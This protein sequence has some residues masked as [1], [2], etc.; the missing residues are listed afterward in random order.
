MWPT[1]HR[2]TVRIVASWLC[3]QAKASPPLPHL[4]G[5]DEAFVEALKSGAPCLWLPPSGRQG[6]QEG[7]ERPFHRSEGLLICSQVQHSTLA[8]QHCRTNR[9]QVTHNALPVLP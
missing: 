7:V 9:L 4:C 6:T 8:R 1:L 3:A 5:H 2:W